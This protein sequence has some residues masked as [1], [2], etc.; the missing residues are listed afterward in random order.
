M[1]AQIRRYGEC[2]GPYRME[3]LHKYL[4][5][6]IYDEEQYSEHGD[7]DSSQDDPDKKEEDDEDEEEE[8]PQDE[9]EEEEKLEESAGAC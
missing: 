4:L 7:G 6:S 8:E 3:E 5:A 2:D 9:P 1:P